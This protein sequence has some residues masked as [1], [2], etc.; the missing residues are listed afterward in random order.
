VLMLSL[1]DFVE[2][3]KGAPVPDDMQ[4]NHY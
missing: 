2:T 1:K 4:V 3:G